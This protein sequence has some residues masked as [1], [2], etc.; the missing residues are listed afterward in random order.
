MVWFRAGC[1]ERCGGVGS[2]GERGSLGPK[3]TA[4]PALPA[5]SPRCG[6]CGGVGGPYHWGGGGYVAQGLVHVCPALEKV[7]EYIGRGGPRDCLHQNVVA[8]VIPR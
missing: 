2:R 5:S 7:K 1:C 6:W 4:S 8:S 3:L